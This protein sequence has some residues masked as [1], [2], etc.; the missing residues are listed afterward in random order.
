[1]FLILQPLLKNNESEALIFLF[2]FFGFRHWLI[3]FTKEN[4]TWNLNAKSPWPFA[5]SH[6]VFPPL[7]FLAINSCNI[8]MIIVQTPIL[9]YRLFGRIHIK[10]QNTDMMITVFHLLRLT[11]SGV[12]SGLLSDTIGTSLYPRYPQIARVRIL[13]ITGR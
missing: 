9:I 10:I 11:I 5:V 4:H 3:R 1:M 6:S 2:V 12:G 13:P 7:Y 8:C